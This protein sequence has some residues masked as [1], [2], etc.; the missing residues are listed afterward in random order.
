MGRGKRREETFVE[1]E[2]AVVRSDE[3]EEGE[4]FEDEELASL[5]IPREHG[6]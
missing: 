6:A 4:D 3:P 1:P 5:T 2:R